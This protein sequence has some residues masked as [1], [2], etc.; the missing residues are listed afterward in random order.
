MRAKFKFDSLTRKGETYTNHRMAIPTLVHSFQEVLGINPSSGFG[1]P[2]GNVG[3][4]DED[5]G[6]NTNLTVHF[7]TCKNQG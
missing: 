1:V 7:Q 4:Y 3:L 2:A 6:L 5:R